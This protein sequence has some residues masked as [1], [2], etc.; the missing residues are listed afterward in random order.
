M[1]KSR[2]IIA[3]AGEKF[4]SL[5]HEFNDNTIRFVLRYPGVIDPDILSAATRAIIEQVDI[6]HGSFY[7]DSLSAY[8]EIHSEYDENSYFQYIR[9]EGDPFVT[10]QSISLL[11]VYHDSRCQL[12]VCLVQNDTESAVAVNISHL[13]VDGGDGKYLLNKLA[14]SYN[15]IFTTGNAAS[16]YVKNGQRA[17][18][19]IY[20]GLNPK[21]MASL[22]KI[23]GSDVKSEFR[24]VNDL[25]GR[26]SMV[27][28]VIPAE[29]MAAARKKAKIVGATA[30]DILLT[31]VY[32]TYAELPYVDENGAMSVMSMMDLRRHCDDGESDGLANMSGT[33]PTVLREGV[34]E[35]FAATLT[36]VASQT[37]A[38]KENPLAGMDGMPLIHGAVRTVPMK[39]LM[40]VA[41]KIYGALALGL[42]NLGNMDC[43]ALAMGEIIPTEG[44]FGG[45][46]KKKPAMQI[47]AASFDGSCSLCIVGQYT[48]E[49]AVMLQAFLDH[50]EEEITAYAKEK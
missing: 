23:P 24:F 48:S 47:S 13:C 1:S 9:T 32:R 35:N 14:E 2:K 30:N 41:G 40:M 43:K 33:F 6:L 36:E 22:I 15:L 42:T 18:E 5:G 27:R 45:P 11:P 16:L 17:P 44:L 50:M 34:E 29:T 21:E 46:L 26:N 7:N 20:Q 8:W 39:I 3:G 38:M 4:Q 49:D 10:A 19:Q 12:R 28:V 25:P 37:R 31:A